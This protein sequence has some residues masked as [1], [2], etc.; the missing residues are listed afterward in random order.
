MTHKH[1]KP[2]MYESAGQVGMIIHPAY[3]IFDKYMFSGQ[4]C[5]G[6]IKYLQCFFFKVP[7]LCFFLILPSFGIILDSN[8]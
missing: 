5:F 7:L 3:L 2:R 8:E 1:N 4:L 6:V